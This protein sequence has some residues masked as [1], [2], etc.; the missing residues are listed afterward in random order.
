MPVALN[1]ELFY[2]GLLRTLP[3][4]EAGLMQMSACAEVPEFGGNLC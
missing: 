4:S 2:S 3:F 1:I